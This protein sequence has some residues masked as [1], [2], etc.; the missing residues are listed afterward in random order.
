M[1]YER[2][3]KK[4]RVQSNTVQQQTHTLVSKRIVKMDIDRDIPQFLEMQRKSMPQDL[5]L[6]LDQFE[7]LY[8][9][10]YV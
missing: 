9:R 1:N 10:K 6:Y 5:W 7:D 8:E 2:T 4:T 3:N